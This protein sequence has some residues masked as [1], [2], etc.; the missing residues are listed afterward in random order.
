MNM[1]LAFNIHKKRLRLIQMIC[2]IELPHIPATT[3]I[4]VTINLFV[5]QSRFNE[6]HYFKCCRLPIPPPSRFV[7]GKLWRLAIIKEQI[8][9]F[10]KLQTLMRDSYVFVC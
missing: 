10:L 5:W 9:V 3:A 1:D 6:K 8:L 7:S 2:T 4:K